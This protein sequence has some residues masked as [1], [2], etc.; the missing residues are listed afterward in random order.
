MRQPKYST[1]IAIVVSVF[2]LYSISLWGMEPVDTLSA[3]MDLQRYVYPQEKINVT[4]D[5]EHYMAGDTIWLRAFVVDASSHCPVDVSR[6]VYVELRNPFNQVEYR[7]KLISRKGEFCGYL[8]LDAKM[9]EGRF[10][11]TAY[12]M[13][14]ENAGE[15]YF[16]KKQVTVSSAFSTKLDIPYKLI[17]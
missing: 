2:S 15:E 9:A 14:M 8:P 7:A 13:F 11:L 17:N 5:K 16:F 4:T 3:R 12:T 10:M 1:I 6:Y